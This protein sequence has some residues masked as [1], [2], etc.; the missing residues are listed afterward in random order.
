MRYGCSNSNDYGTKTSIVIRDF[1]SKPAGRVVA[2]IPREN[3]H[4]AQ[5]IGQVLCDLL[6]NNNIDL[7]RFEKSVLIKEL[8]NKEK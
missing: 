3:V 2:V 5:Q 4:E 1:G 8:T 7:T 6:N